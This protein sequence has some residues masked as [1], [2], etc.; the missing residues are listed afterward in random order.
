MFLFVCN[1]HFLK[2]RSLVTHPFTRQLV[3]LYQLDVSP[4][5]DKSVPDRKAE[6][7]TDEGSR[8]TDC[9]LEIILMLLLSG[10][11]IS[12]GVNS[13]QSDLRSR[14]YQVLLFILFIYLFLFHVLYFLPTDPPAN[15]SVLAISTTVLSVSWSTT[16]GAVYYRIVCIL[17]N[18]NVS[19]N[20]SSILLS[21]LTP[22][23]NYSV[24]YA[25]CSSSSVCSAYNQTLASTCKF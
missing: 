23:T 3:I 19:T 18:V 13:R 21:S 20:A 17:C 24:S 6:I 11:C 5:M 22:G 14:I 16:K 9:F 12:G 8:M 4:A 25:S 1:V 10:T 7:T 2:H 15:F